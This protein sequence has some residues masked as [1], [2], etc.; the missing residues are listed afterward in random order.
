[1]AL[2]SRFVRRVPTQPA[3]RVIVVE[4]RK[5]RLPLYFRNLNVSCHGV[6]HVLPVRMRFK[7]FGMSR[8]GQPLAIYACPQY[9]CRCQQ[10][11]TQHRATGEPFR[12]WV[13]S[14]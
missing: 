5:P 14:H 4:R 8:D 13:R 11:W 3:P 12:L 7:S 2:F 1:M 6:D 10:A 9:L